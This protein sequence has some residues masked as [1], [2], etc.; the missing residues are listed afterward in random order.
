MSNKQYILGV[1][2]GNTKTDYF[3]FQTDGTLCAWQREGTCSHEALGGYDK[4]KAIIRNALERLLHSCK[5]SPSQIQ[6][7]VFGL[8]GV[9]IPSQQ[10]RMSQVIQSLGFKK[11]LVCNDGFLGI[12]AAAPD[13]VGIC[14]ISGTGTVT[15]GIDRNGDRLQVGGIGSITQ[16]FAGG[17]YLTRQAISAAYAHRLRNGP[18]FGATEWIEEKLQITGRDQWLE[19]IHPAL[20]EIGPFMT[21]LIQLLFKLVYSGDAVAGHIVETSATSLA[22]GVLGC[23]Q[24]QAYDKNVTV[25]LA[26]SIWIKCNCQYMKQLFLDKI[27]AETSLKIELVPL[28]VPP[29]LGA[30]YWAWELSQNR[31]VESS[32]KE[33][34]YNAIADKAL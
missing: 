28:Q 30:V 16:D 19:K 23:I 24:N 22:N 26:G 25:I 14:S 32:I 12:K 4:A 21:E 31:W 17:G 7:A 13:G 20:L 34:I 10:S 1:D 33:Q 27:H 29:V 6:A 15:V 5:I 18:D 2:G 11:F 8:A 3:L 9:D